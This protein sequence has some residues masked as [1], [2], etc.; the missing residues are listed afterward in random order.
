M[1]Y[2]I[3]G[4]P[5][6]VADLVVENGRYHLRCVESVY[7]KQYSRHP[8]V[9]R[10]GKVDAIVLVLVLDDLLRIGKSQPQVVAGFR[11]SVFVE[12]DHNAVLQPPKGGLG[13]RFAVDAAK[14]SVDAKVDRL[15]ATDWWRAWRRRWDT[16]QNER[17][18]Q[19]HE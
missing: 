3:V 19:H 16:P 1:V 9:I 18:E 10:Q 12:L 6:D 11:I 13:E 14:A 2:P 7:H 17:Q 5:Q 8:G 4:H 15:C